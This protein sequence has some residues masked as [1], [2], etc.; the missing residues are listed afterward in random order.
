[1]HI[2]FSIMSYIKSNFCMKFLRS[3]GSLRGSKVGDFLLLPPWP[4]MWWF[5]HLINFQIW[6]LRKWILLPMH[7][8]PDCPGWVEVWG[9]YLSGGSSWRPIWDFNEEEVNDEYVGMI[10]VVIYIYVIKLRASSVN[11][12][13][14]TK[15]LPWWATLPKKGKWTFLSCNLTTGFIST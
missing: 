4:P 7:G 11:F 14:L 15:S 3:D 12:V 6:L 2:I 5:K 10:L 8:D 13:T 9:S 1:M